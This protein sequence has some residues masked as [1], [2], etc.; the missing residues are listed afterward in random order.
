MALQK[1]DSRIVTDARFDHVVRIRRANP[2]ATLQEIGDKCGVTREA[3]RQLLTKAGLPTKG[4]RQ[5]YLC[6][7]CGGLISDR[8]RRSSHSP[9]CSP[10][11]YHKYHNVEMVCGYCGKTVERRVS[12]ILVYPTRRNS[13][14]CHSFCSRTCYQVWRKGRPLKVAK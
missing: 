11:C 13:D 6:C 8:V 14:K 12:D 4:F 3:V 5:Q 2:C 10:E 9:F 1:G 7:V